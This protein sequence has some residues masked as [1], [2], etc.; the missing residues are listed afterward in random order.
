[1][2]VYVDPLFGTAR[3]RRWPYDVACHMTA[4]SFDELHAFAARI[5]LKHSWFQADS[6]LPHYD[7]T[8]GVRAR[9]VR[10]GAIE[11]SA[12]EMGRKCREWRARKKEVMRT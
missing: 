3:T 10:L 11:I 8:P 1:M 4:D 9:A 5:G 12:V 2:S 7:L 6:S